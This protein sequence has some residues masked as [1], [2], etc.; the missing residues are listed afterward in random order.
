[1]YKE[2]EMSL[3]PTYKGDAST[4]H[5]YCEGLLEGELMEYLDIDD[6]S[7]CVY[8]RNYH[9]KIGV[10]DRLVRF[11]SFLLLSAMMAVER[12]EQSVAEYLRHVFYPVK[13]CCCSSARANLWLLQQVLMDMVLLNLTPACM[14][15]LLANRGFNSIDCLLNGLA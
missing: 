15:V 9:A 11:G 7:Q 6:F 3:V 13:K 1:M 8:L 10:L 12:Q 2:K 4:P 14:I 5:E